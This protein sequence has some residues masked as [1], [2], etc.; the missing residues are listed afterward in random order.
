MHDQS[1]NSATRRPVTVGLEHLTGPARGTVTWLSGTALDAS[2]GD[3]RRVRISEPGGG[4]SDDA[5]VAR[6]HRSDETYEIEALAPVR[7]DA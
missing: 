2:L 1:V 3:S 6:L 5:V 7:S 4:H